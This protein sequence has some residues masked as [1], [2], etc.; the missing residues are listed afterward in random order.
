ML[1]QLTL[2]LVNGA[3]SKISIQNNKLS[4]VKQQLQYAIKH[5]LKS[6]ESNLDQLE[7]KLELLSP[8]TILKRG[9]TLTSVNNKLLKKH[10]KLGDTLITE[11]YISKITSIVNEIKEK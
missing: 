7:N 3:Q 2:N 10:P 8:E 5:R 9:Y 4:I 6:D 1:N 11:T